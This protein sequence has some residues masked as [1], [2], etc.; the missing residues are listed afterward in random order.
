MIAAA[1]KASLVSARIN[2]GIYVTEAVE[3][4]INGEAIPVDWCK[5]L[6]DDAVYLS[7]LNTDII[8]EGTQE[9]IEAAAEKIKSGELQIFAGPLKGTSPEGEAIELA[10]GEAFPEQKEA[11]APSWV[12]IVEGCSVSQ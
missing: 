10:D 2:W 11:S 9:A 12:Y 1:P 5:G 7:A 3:A 4:V 8:A 6:A